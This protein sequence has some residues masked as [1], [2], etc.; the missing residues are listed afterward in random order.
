MNHASLHGPGANAALAGRPSRRRVLWLCSAGW[1]WA[2]AGCSLLRPRPPAAE[3]PLWQG[4]LA[5]QIRSDPPESL[6]ASFELSGQ[7]ASGELLLFSPL[8]TRLATLQW[9]PG[10]ASLSASQGTQIYASLDDLATAHQAGVLPI[11]A[12]FDWLKGQDRAVAGWQVDLSRLAEGRL[13]AQRI[14][15]LPAAQ[16]R[17]VLD[18]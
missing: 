14:S 15:P 12:L 10:R 4:R 7:A 8:G 18:R 17:I 2:G 9:Q 6:S 3:A 13:Q 5:L 1:A 16:L 11:A